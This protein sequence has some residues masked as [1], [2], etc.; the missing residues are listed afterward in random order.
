[1]LRQIVQVGRRKLTPSHGSEVASDSASGE[2]R[3]SRGGETDDEED[4]NSLEPWVA[5]ITRATHEAEAAA[6]K[7]HVRNWVSSQQLMKFKLAGH[8]LRRTDERWSRQALM[9]EPRGVRRSAH[10]FT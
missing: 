5:W 2:E 4:D 7:T 3:E 6:Q 10:P 8:I 1:M 9:W